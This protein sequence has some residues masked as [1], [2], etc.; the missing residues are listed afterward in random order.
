MSW[1]LVAESIVRTIEQAL[2]DHACVIKKPE[3]RQC[4]CG[5]TVLVFCAICEDPLALITHPDWPHCEHARPMVP[6]L[7]PTD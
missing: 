4:P 3:M 5:H 7:T 1:A 2:A 6:Y